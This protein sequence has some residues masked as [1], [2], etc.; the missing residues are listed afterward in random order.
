MDSHAVSL[1]QMSARQPL[2]TPN[3]VVEWKQ[4]ARRQARES[5]FCE[6]RAHYLQ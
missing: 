3:F 6:D 4:K 5:A 2:F 1:G